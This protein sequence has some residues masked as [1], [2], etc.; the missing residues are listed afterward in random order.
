VPRAFPG[1]SSLD[2]L[3]EAMRGAQIRCVF[4]KLTCGSSGAGIAVFT[5]GSRDS[6][7]STVE[8]DGPRL[9]NTKRVQH[10]VRASEVERVIGFLLREG[11][12]VE[13][14]VPKARLRGLPFDCRILIM[15]GEPAFG[16][17]RCSASP[18]A[19]LHLGARPVP[20]EEIVEAVPVEACE[21]ALASVRR[22]Y[23]AHDCFHLGVDL[24]FAEGGLDHRVLEANA[25]GDHLPKL[26]NQGQSVYDWQVERLRPMLLA[27]E[28]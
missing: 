21:A 25:F 10:Y 20:I 13:E 3:R 11:A 9:Y 7:T 24:L 6:V 18:I 22:V 15:D 8:I 14:C 16:V 23:E 4:V 2:E 17:A 5:S 12:H 27:S 28:S 1:V 26:R 19:N